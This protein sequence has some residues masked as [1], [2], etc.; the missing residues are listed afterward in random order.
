MAQRSHWEKALLI[1]P[2]ILLLHLGYRL[3]DQSQMIQHFPLDF[4][5]DVSSY[6][7]QLHFLEVCGF[8]QPCQYWYNGFTAFKFSPPGW[9]FLFFPLQLLLQ[10]VQLVT[11]LSLLIS[12]SAGFFLLWHCSKS[13]GF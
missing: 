1:T 8:H 13:A 4:A 9:Y 6:M 12:L 5:N 2:L 10:N 7:A 3:L 11:Y